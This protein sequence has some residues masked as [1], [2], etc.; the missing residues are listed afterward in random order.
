MIHSTGR[1]YQL[2]VLRLL[3]GEDLRTTLET[4]CKERK[5]E[6]AAVV[7]AVGSV[8]KAMIRFGGRSEGNSVEGDLEVCALSGTLSQHGMHLH[9]AVADAEGNTLGGHLLAGTLVRTTLEIVVHEIGGLRFLRKKDE[10]TGFM[11][12]FP[13][14]IV[15]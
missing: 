14:P 3:P 15:P 9:I 8:S 5:V 6:A 7:S 11:E 13:E 12:L 4:W 10:R 2:H 1:P